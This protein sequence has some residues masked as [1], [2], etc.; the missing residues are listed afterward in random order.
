LSAINSEGSSEVGGRRP[1][2]R[3]MLDGAGK[4]ARHGR[5]VALIG[6]MEVRRDHSARVE[7]HC[8][9]RLVDQTR[10][11]IFQL[12]DP[13]IRIGRTFP[14]R[15]GLLLPFAVAVEPDQI[16]RS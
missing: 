15:V 9:L 1:H 2:R 11:P 16:R 10:A 6:G 7:V 12:G 4:C 14:V 3:E 13:G 5:P 8:V